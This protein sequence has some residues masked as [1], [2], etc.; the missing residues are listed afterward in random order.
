M[1]SPARVGAEQR[2][3]VAVGSGRDQVQRD[4]AA[5]GHHRALE[6]L[7]APIHRRAAGDL[8]PARGL[9]DAAID[10]QVLELQPDHPVVGLQ[11]QRVDLLAQ[12]GRGPLLQPPPDGRVRAARGW[13]SARTPSHAPARRCTCSNTTR[14]GMRRRWQPSGWVGETADAP[15]A[16]P[17]TGPRAAPT[18]MTGSTGTGSSPTAMAGTSTVAGARACPLRP[19]PRQPIAGHS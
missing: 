17:R 11:R 19:I 3:V 4:A 12:P 2:R 18:G 16:A 5:F 10:R 13:R 7:L 1:S 15:A 9:G 8:A 6:P 14:S